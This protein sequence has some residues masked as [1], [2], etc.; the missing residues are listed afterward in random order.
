MCRHNVEFAS[1][2][3][4]GNLLF[5]LNLEF[6]NLSR[7]Y[8][9]M[10]FLFMK[11]FMNF[12]PSYASISKNMCLAFVTDYISCDFLTQFHHK[13]DQRLLEPWHLWRQLHIE[14]EYT[15]RD[16]RFLLMTP[17][18]LQRFW[19]KTLKIHFK[20]KFT[21]NCWECR[22]ALYIKSLQKCYI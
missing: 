7:T 11:K 9:L 6:L 19:D 17:L 15:S 4:A 18:F 16:V 5:F 12:R 13:F 20:R 1:Y 22:F 3:T 21:F 14:F 8:R 10:K 2:S